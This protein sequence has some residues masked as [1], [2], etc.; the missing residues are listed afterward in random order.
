MTST[1]ELAARAGDPQLRIIDCRF[2]LMAPEA[3]RK[4]WLDGHIPGAVYA[5]LDRDLSGPVTAESGRHPLPS[6]ESAT[7]TFSRLG[8]DARTRVVACDDASGAIAARAWWLLRW[9]GH[10]QVTVLDGG[11]QAWRSRGLP[12]EAGGHAVE[13]RQFRAAPNP[14]RILGTREIAAGLHPHRDH[15]LVDARDAARYRGEVEPI[16]TRAGHIPGT[17]NLPYAACLADDGTWLDE[18]AL[19]ERL[20][21]LL[22][23]DPRAPW[24]VMCGSGVTACH[25]AISGLLAGFSEPRLYVGSWSEWIRDPARPIERTHAQ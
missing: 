3:G 17:A 22:G 24:A 18:A 6:V 11:I 14:L 10:E 21:P 1:D 7:E 25:L 9:L 13:R 2:D 5:D 19:R 15:V 23:D 12:M 16:D 8:I 20:G 4:A